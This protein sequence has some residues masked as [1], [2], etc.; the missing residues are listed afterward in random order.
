MRRRSYALTIVV[1]AERC[2]A[3]PFGAQFRCAI[4]GTSSLTIAHRVIIST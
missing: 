2:S 4:R 1:R 3:P